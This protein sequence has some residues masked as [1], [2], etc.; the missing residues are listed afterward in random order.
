MAVSRSD[1]SSSLHGKTVPVRFL[2]P[3]GEKVCVCAR[4]RVQVRVR[5]RASRRALTLQGAQVGLG[6]NEQETFGSIKERIW[7]KK[8]IEDV[9]VARPRSRACACACVSACARV[10]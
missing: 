6:V 10:G 3:N 1:S 4:A 7:A 8:A 9:R 2:L 5:V